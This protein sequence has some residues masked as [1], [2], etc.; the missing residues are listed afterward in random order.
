MRL[1]RSSVRLLFGSLVYLVLVSSAGAQPN[2]RAVLDGASFGP[3]VSPGSLVSIFG[4]E[5]A[6][7]T[8]AA[9]EVPSWTESPLLSTVWRPRFTLSLRIRSTHRSH[10]ALARRKWIWSSSP[11]KGRVRRTRSLYCPPRRESLPEAAMAKGLPCSWIPPLRFS[12][13]LLPG[14][15]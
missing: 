3:L 8:D 15:A 14:S 5:L 9:S 11:G 2:I 7:S 12:R 4:T 1:G 10:S 13:R 6:Q